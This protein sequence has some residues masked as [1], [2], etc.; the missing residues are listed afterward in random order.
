MRTAGLQIIWEE[1]EKAREDWTDAAGW[2]FGSA[3]SAWMR[4][5]RSARLAGF[6]RDAAPRRE[7]PD[8]ELPR[9]ATRVSLVAEGYGRFQLPMF[10]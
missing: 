7:S 8:G 9:R 6:G 4:F 3:C 1:S 5:L 2:G 10:Q